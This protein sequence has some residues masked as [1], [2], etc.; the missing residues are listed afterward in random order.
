MTKEIILITAN[1]PYY[2]GEQFLETEIGYWE[3]TKNI[4]LTIMPVGIGTDK[5]E[6]SKNISIDYSLINRAKKNQTRLIYILKSLKNKMFYIEVYKQ[7]LKQPGRFINGL[8]SFVKYL[9]FK[10]KLKL[11]LISNKDKKLVFYT[12]WHTEVTYA[13]QSL[14]QEYDFLLVTRTHR[15]D[16]YEETRKY[17]YMP[18]RRQF[19]HNIDKI[20]TI[21]KSAEK[22]LFETYGFEKNII[23]MSRLGVNQYNITSV[24]NE[25]K[26]Y[27]IVSCSFLTKVKRIDKLIDAIA[28][29][30]GTLEGINL[31]W[32][33]IGSGEL[34]EELKKYAHHK[35][36][37]ISNVSYEYLG[38][39]KNKE[40][41]MFYKNNNIDVFI[42]VSASEGVPVSIMEAM[43]CHIPIIAP[44]I[45]GINEMI[46]DK[47]NGI[48]LDSEPSIDEITKGL[49]NISFFKE[50]KSRE[51]AY[52]V[53]QD[54]YSSQYNYPLF[55]QSI[56]K[57]DNS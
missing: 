38:E 31:I 19:L 27:H 48:L 26:I 35:F 34:E 54:K 4:H 49:T 41:Y 11:F 21:T 30:A 40:V 14:K 55:I 5:R 12:Y 18:I 36:K 2:P 15:F 9:Y 56:L 3:K 51:N 29:L 20:F 47:Y 7:I 32:T 8:I 23:E 46:I 10:E 17:Q 57:L 22:Y 53:Y 52:K 6:M 16:I 37:N 13:L 42:N 25:E 33:H 24:P 45:G 1:F 39:L 44:D 28:G 43:S 50:K